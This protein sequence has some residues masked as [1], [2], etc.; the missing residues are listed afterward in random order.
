MSENSSNVKTSTTVVAGEL[1][2]TV[3]NIIFVVEGGIGKHII[4]TV[5]IR[6]IKKKYPNTAKIKIS[7][8]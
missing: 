2:S 7:F 4:S 8:E 1:P 3:E 5:V 6:N